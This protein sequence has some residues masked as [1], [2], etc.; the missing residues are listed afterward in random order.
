MVLMY[1]LY[2]V[3]NNKNILKSCKSKHKYNGWSGP[4]ITIAG[5]STNNYKYITHLFDTYLNYISKN[6]KKWGPSN[7]TFKNNKYNIISSTLSYL[8]GYLINKIDKLKQINSWN[9]YCPH[10]K[11]HLYLDNSTWSLQM[12][13]YNNI[14]NKIKRLNKFKLLF[15]DIYQSLPY[16][17]TVLSYNV[18]YKAMTGLLQHCMDNSKNICLQ[19]ISAVIDKYSITCDFIALQEP[20][21]IE[22]MIK[23]SPNLSKMKIIKTNSGP[24]LMLTVYNPLKWTIYKYTDSSYYS[25]YIG[26]IGRPIQILIFKEKLIFVNVHCPHY[27]YDN[28]NNFDG[29]NKDLNKCFENIL[30]KIKNNISIFSKFRIIIAGDFNSDLHDNKKKFII[31]YNKIK[32]QFFF[33]KNKFKTCCVTYNKDDTFNKPPYQFDFILDTIPPINTELVN[34][35][36]I[37]KHSDH[38]P[39][40]SNLFH[41]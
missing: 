11:K 18:Y 20:A 23:L 15:Y 29:M 4:H 21:A 8:H 24:E 6:N 1:G 25:D 5:F 27:F 41:I 40:Y 10:L 32:R 30:N 34:I 2:L 14:N 36:K 17:I 39:I 37:Y 31:T 16:N 35:Q 33:H 38:L 13:E 26:K 7:Y 22:K 12:I 28:K 19:N 9:I 3:P